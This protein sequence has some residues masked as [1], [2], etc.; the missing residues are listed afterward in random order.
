M[1][2]PHQKAAIATKVGLLISITAAIAFGLYPAAAKAAYRSGA[3]FSFVIILTTFARALALLIFCGLTN[4][5]VF[6][7]AQMRKPALIG[8]FW[9]SVSVF[10]IIGSLAYVPAPVTIIIMFTHTV[11]LL[12]YMAYKGEQLLDRFV[13]LTTLAALLGVSLVVDLW[14][15]SNNLNFIGLALALLAAI[16]TTIRLY[17][18]GKEVLTQNPAVVGAQVFS[19]AAVCSL[20]LCLIDL[21]IPPQDSQGFI[22]LLA[23]CAS[24]II[25]TFGMFYGIALLGSF[26]WSLMAKLEPVFTALFAFLILGETLKLPQY[27]GMLL[28]LFSLVTYQYISQ[29]RK[30]S[31]ASHV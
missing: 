4:K 28:V 25:G 30:A 8:G 16:A 10:G 5:T 12:F 13:I 27:L 19:V 24:L 2:H 26:Q 15:N 23:C 9:Q 31:S 1:N 20:A 14:D 29:R 6:P 18:F 17:V 21:P 11:M 7:P 22:W 3:N